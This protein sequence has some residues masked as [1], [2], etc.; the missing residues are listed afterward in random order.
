MNVQRSGH[1]A[2]AKLTPDARRA[3]GLG[4]TPTGDQV[5]AQFAFEHGVDVGVDALVGDV[6]LRFIG[7]HVLEAARDLRSRPY[8]GQE[9]MDDTKERGIGDQLEGF[10]AFEATASRSQAGWRGVVQSW[11]VIRLCMS[12]Q[13]GA[14]V[15]QA[16]CDG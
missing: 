8:P 14:E 3:L 6:D 2:P 7:S 5:F 15:C 4:A 12:M 9:M 13:P 11:S 16:V 10:A 1:L